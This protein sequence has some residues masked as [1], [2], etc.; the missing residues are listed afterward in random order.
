MDN[1]YDVVVI[2]G[3]AAGLTAAIT[4]RRFY[5]EKSVIIVRKEEKVLIPCGIPYIYGT[6]ESPLKNLVPDAVLEKNNIEL[7]VGNVTAIDISSKTIETKK[8]NRIKYEKLIIATGSIPAV[9]PIS[10]SEKENVYV[11][12]KDVNY[13]Q[14]LLDKVESSSDMIIIGGGF[15]GM[16]F[17]DE[18]NKNRD[19]N[20]T[21]VEMLPCCL[22]IAFDEDICRQGEDILKKNGVNIITNAKVEA[23]V[24]DVK[25]EGVKFSDGKIIKA[26]VVLIG[27]GSKPNTEIAKNSGIEL[28]EKGSI[29]VNRYMQT[30][31]EDIFACGDCCEKISF[32]TKKLSNMMLASIACNEARIAGANLY[33]N[34]RANEGVVGVFAT[35]FGET[36][37]ARAG[38]SL[39]EAKENG[40][41]VVAGTAE[42]PNTHPGCMPGGKNLKVIL[43]FERGTGIIL[44]GQLIGSKSG[45]EMINL[46]SACI[47]EK[48][49]ANNMATFQMGTHPALTA[50]PVAYQISNAAEMAVKELRK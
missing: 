10:G 7:L 9:P 31:D 23:I 29:K 34:N 18:C 1:S 44:G 17:A 45:G 8:G 2:G 26:D 16:E 32:F 12:N 4:S 21:V 24:G 50:S 38:L 47:H 36:A 15:I 3:S 37:L 5:P 39:Q 11:I 22:M 48:M 42:A 13:L 30:S 14:N 6:L 40:Y 27:I 25:V 41:D 46:I 28:G 33:K 49:T 20:I 43:I 35:A 19:I